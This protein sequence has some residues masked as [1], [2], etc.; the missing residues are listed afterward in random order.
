MLSYYR[1]TLLSLFQD[2]H[3]VRADPVAGREKCHEIQERLI[4]KIRYIERQI[5]KTKL[6]IKEAKRKLANRLPKAEAQECKNEIDYCQYKVDEYQYLLWILRTVGDTLACIYI[7]RWDTKLMAAKEHA[8]ALSQKTGFRYELKMWRAAFDVGYMAVLLNDLTNCLRHGDITIVTQDKVTMVEVK[9]GKQSTPRDHRQRA[10]LNDL[11][12]YLKTGQKTEV[13]G[14]RGEYTRM[15][16]YVPVED[17]HHR[18]Q[19]NHL[20]DEA[21]KAGSAAGR[22]EDGLFY[23]IGRDGSIDQETAMALLAS[24]DI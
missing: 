9:S 8:G 24:L 13:Y 16:V 2:V 12:S 23:L 18:E 19:L 4:E 10:T 1:R 7:S 6:R 11:V 20:I 5:R 17:D 22:V 21:L 14:N 15:R 3:I